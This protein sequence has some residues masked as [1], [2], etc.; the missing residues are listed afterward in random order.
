M[1]KPTKVSFHNIFLHKTWNFGKKLPVNIY[2]I[3]LM[4]AF[5]GII[6]KPNTFLTV[7]NLMN[8]ME[9]CTVLSIV[10]VAACLAIISKGV[11]LSIGM[12]MSMAGV[13]AAQLGSEMGWPVPLAFL[14]AILSGTF[15]GMLNGIIISTNKVA[16]FIITLATTSIAR[17]FAYIF[18]GI[19]TVPAI[20]PS[21]RWIGSA[22]V[23][24]IVPV[25]IFLVLIIYWLINYLA[26][27]RKL[28]TYIYAVG[29][30]EA[31]AKL[32]GI[33]V[34][35]VKFLTYTVIG[36]LSGIA[37]VMLA[38]RLGAANPEQGQGFEFF[39]IASAV[40]GGASMLGGRGSIWKTLSGAFII[41]TLRNG[42]NIAQ[43][44]TSL[45]MITLGIVI[46]GVVTADIFMRK[47]S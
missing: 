24:G 34:Q 41:A 6:T 44:H 20:E 4:F 5:F 8:I 28:G 31:V 10:A 19:R 29:G 32:S 38:A 11:D 2:V 46:V 23:F 42:L 12:T 26:T 9:Q 18:S 15:I 43:M 22:Y 7:P 39:G 33:N 45:Q 3:I 25:G 14:V 36:T 35:R 17:S 37:G 47:E 40:V 13:I 21:F 1:S 16:P 27:K 30:N